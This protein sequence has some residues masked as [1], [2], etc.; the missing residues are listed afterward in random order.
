MTNKNRKN[1][2]LQ[3]NWNHAS[4]SSIVKVNTLKTPVVNIRR[5]NL[6]QAT[7]CRITS[8]AMNGNKLFNS[9][10]VVVSPL[11]FPVVRNVRR[12]IFPKITKCLTGKCL[13]C[14]FL[15]TESNVVSSVNNR[16]FNC[17]LKQNVT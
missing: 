3:T 10:R 12:S 13:C 5:L 4:S 11:K 8:E 16:K 1:I 6:H 15:Q 9:L 2:D 17:L 7:S 14:S